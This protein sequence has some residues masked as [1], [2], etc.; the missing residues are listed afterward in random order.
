MYYGTTQHTLER[1]QFSLILARAIDILFERAI[2]QNDPEAGYDALPSTNIKPD[3]ASTLKTTKILLTCIEEAITRLTQ[4]GKIARNVRISDQDIS[5]IL[6]LY[7]DVTRVGYLFYKNCTTPL[8]GKQKVTIAASAIVTGLPIIPFAISGSFDFLTS[9]GVHKHLAHILSDFLG[10][11]IGTLTW[12]VFGAFLVR[13]NL[14][15]QESLNTTSETKRILKNTLKGSN[16]IKTT[17]QYLLGI[18]SAIGSFNLA[19]LFFRLEWLM[20]ML[21]WNMPTGLLG[22]I[23]QYGQDYL[24][25]IPALI[26][27]Y[28]S[29]V[30]NFAVVKNL[31]AKLAAFP[32][33]CSALWY[34]DIATHAAVNVPWNT[35]RKGLQHCFPSYI[36][37]S[38]TFAMTHQEINT[39]WEL[40]CKLITAKIKL[41][42]GMTDAELFFLHH[43]IKGLDELLNNALDL[44]NEP[45]PR[46]MRLKELIKTQF[47]I[48][49]LNN[50]LCEISKIRANTHK[51]VVALL[52]A[53]SSL[54]NEYYVGSIQNIGP[55][56]LPKAIALSSGI[57]V[58]ALNAVVSFAA[59]EDSSKQVTAR[60]NK[61]PIL[62]ALFCIPIIGIVATYSFLQ[63]VEENNGG[64]Y[65]HSSFF[66]YLWHLVKE[67]VFPFFGFD[68]QLILGTFGFTGLIEAAAAY[69]TARFSSTK[70]YTF[71]TEDVRAAREWRCQVKGG[72]DLLVSFSGHMDHEILCA[73]NTLF[74]SAVADTLFEEV[75]RELDPEIVDE[76][77]DAVAAAEEEEK[78]SASSVRKPNIKA[79][80]YDPKAPCG[81][82]HLKASNLNRAVNCS[83]AGH[84]GYRKS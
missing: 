20:I 15:F 66:E 47:I 7:I 56:Q 17:L 78:V 58:A 46:Q 9:I 4:E 10:T 59:G 83:I 48:I 8:S 21:G 60:T 35:L 13:G 23:F 44:D 38:K 75:C 25:I 36:S 12:I 77:E 37:P 74:S 14:S 54:G 82:W 2:K 27:L 5:D 1:D 42:Y 24:P 31:S 33:L 71:I 57:V 79:L 81:M 43:L 70:K 52:L 11:P 73:L 45:K 49:A 22:T 53:V 29:T 67:F 39:K 72:L 61:T 65:D 32:L 68:V 40:R 76:E 63:A 3:D 26:P 64:A 6:D 28:F 80:G 62:L 50:N 41:E 19:Y 30:S 34:L 51:I 16:S 55:W 84:R 69:I 18:I